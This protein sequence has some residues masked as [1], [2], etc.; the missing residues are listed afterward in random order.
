[1][2]MLHL[3]IYMCITHA[4][5]HVH[6]A[7]LYTWSIPQ[8]AW[9]SSGGFDIYQNPGS[10]KAWGAIGADGCADS[11]TWRGSDGRTCDWFADHDPWCTRWADEG[12]STACPKACGVCSWSSRLRHHRP[13]AMPLAREHVQTVTTVRKVL[14]NT[15]LA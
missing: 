8:G 10:L 12:Q 2:C 1:M 6:S 14:A 7:W 15:R 11:T 5:T 3:C 9:R 13:P 4:Y